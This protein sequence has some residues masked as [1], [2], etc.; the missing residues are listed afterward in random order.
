MIPAPAAVGMPVSGIDTPALVLD[1]DALDRNIARMATAAAAAGIDL[2]PH[3]KCHKSVDIAR[4]Q[5][6][7]GA[8]GIT[9][10][11]VSEAEVF[12]AAGMTDVLISNEVVAPA[13]VERVAALASAARIAVC[14]DD[15]S[16]VLALNSAA[17]VAGAT[18][19]VLVEL[20]TAEYRPG[21]GPG[22][23]V[24]A[25][26]M[27]AAEATHLSFGGIQA[28]SGPAQHLRSHSERRAVV[29]R[30][31]GDV[32][33]SVTLLEEHGID[34]RRVTGAGTGTYD[35]E[36]ASEVFTEIQPGS[37]VFMDGDYLANLDPEGGP[38][39][40]FE[41]SLF[42]L[43][44]VMSRREGV[45]VLDAG[46]KAVAMG[47][48][49]P[50]VSGVDGAAYDQ[51][52]DEHVTIALGPGVDGPALGEM[53]RLI[54]YNCDPTVNLYDWFIGVSGELVAEVW[55]VSA[56]GAIS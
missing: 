6:E 30:V 7:A 8:V 16:N 20:N 17:R 49:L 54:P 1:L 24:F 18:I 15:A 41:T 32:E 52:G 48:G 3:A 25:L 39:R 47:N 31:A 27:Q 36:P 34:C 42:V 44:G 46:S 12:V 2:R 22:D 5:I 40:D 14:V 43:A 4:R 21:V 50:L 35:L 28:Y 13:K 37:Y 55:P 9:C 45:A 29:D 10:Q 11:K 33:R 19:E 51:F 38:F 53:V 23:P 56:R 26:A